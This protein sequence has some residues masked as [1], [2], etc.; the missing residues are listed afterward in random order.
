MTVSDCCHFSDI[1]IS[2]GSIATRVRCGELLID[3]FTT[4]LLL[5]FGTHYPCPRAVSTARGHGCPKWCPWTRSVETCSV[6][7]R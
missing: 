2:Q 7:W 5:K 4:D 1:N 3:S 6:Y